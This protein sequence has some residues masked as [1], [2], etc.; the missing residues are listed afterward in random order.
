MEILYFSLGMLTVAIVFAVGSV[1][2]L[3]RMF[4]KSSV[5]NRKSINQLERDVDHIHSRIN[6]NTD[7][8]YRTIDSRLDK[9]EHR[10]SN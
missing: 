4:K 9:L 6:E 5:R 8:L 3:K 2:K 1:F 7:E 10:L